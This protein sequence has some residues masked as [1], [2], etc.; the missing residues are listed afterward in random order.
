[1]NIGEVA[2]RTG[3]TSKSI[4]LYEQKGLIHSLRSENGYR[5]YTDTQVQQLVL[6]ARAKNLGFNLDDCKELV[7]LSQ[8]NQMQSSAV[9][10]KTMAKIAEIEQKIAD[11]TLMKNTLQTWAALCPGNDSNNC[12][13]ME[14]LTAPLKQKGE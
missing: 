13:I 12:P 8:N 3:L 10:G 1:M 11:L 2:K 9:K 6:I 14:G 5:T 7:Q 4:R